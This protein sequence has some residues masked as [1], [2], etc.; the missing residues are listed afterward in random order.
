[1][2]DK[3]RK[4]IKKRKKYEDSFAYKGT[5]RLKKDELDKLNAKRGNMSLAEYC[6]NAALK[7]KE[8]PSQLSSLSAARLSEMRTELGRLGNNINQIA[9]QANIERINKS[10]N[11][12]DIVDQVNLTFPML[13]KVLLTILNELKK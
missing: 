9:R 6:I 8:K 1:M 10:S 7:K 13:R 12:S 11:P 2:E 5:F 3:N 4:E